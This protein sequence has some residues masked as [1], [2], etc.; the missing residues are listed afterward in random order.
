[1]ISINF[2]NIKIVLYIMWKIFV[3]SLWIKKIFLIIYYIFSL[4]VNKEK[5]CIKNYNKYHKIKL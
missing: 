5:I 2:Y 3:E 1:M 4:S